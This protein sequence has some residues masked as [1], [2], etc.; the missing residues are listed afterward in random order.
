MSHSHA[1]TP[2]FVSPHSRGLTVQHHT[3]YSLT[4]CV[5]QQRPA[6]VASPIFS[7]P[8]SQSSQTLEL[9]AILYKKTTTWLSVTDLAKYLLSDTSIKANNSLLTFGYKVLCIEYTWSR[10]SRAQSCP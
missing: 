8:R 6:H 9:T 5:V 7:R 1:L 10:I 4:F 3:L 2:I